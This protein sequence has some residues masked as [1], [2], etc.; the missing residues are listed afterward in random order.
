MK[1]NLSPGMNRVEITK[2]DQR[3]VTTFT[4]FTKQR[5][6]LMKGYKEAK[7]ND[8]YMKLISKYAYNDI[9]DLYTRLRRMKTSP[10]SSAPSAH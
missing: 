1:E 9:I 5:N 6:R 4:Q 10:Q 7:W 2:D 8:K 3:L